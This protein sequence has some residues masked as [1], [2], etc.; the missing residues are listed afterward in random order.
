MSSDGP[1][2]SA[3]ALP[4]GEVNHSLAY[5]RKSHDLTPL[6]EA[7]RWDRRDAWVV[8]LLLAAV[9]AAYFPVLGL[10]F[11]NWDDPYILFRNRTLNPPT[12]ASVRAW[13]TRPHEG[14]Y[15]PVAYTVWGAVAFIHW[16]PAREA[17]TG[18]GLHPLPFHALNLV[19]FSIT[20]VVVYRLLRRLVGPHWPAA[21]GALLFALHPIQVESV[22]HA[23]GV[24]GLLCVLFSLLALGQY[25][26][27][28]E[29]SPGRRTLPGGA[30]WPELP[31]ARWR[32]YVLA[33]LLFVIAFLC[34]PLGMVVPVMAGVLDVFFVGRPVRRAAIALAPWLLLAV[35][36]AVWTKSLQPPPRFDVQIPWWFRPGVAAD[37]VAVYL[38]KLVF[39][40]H[41]GLTYGRTPASLMR[42]DAA[43][44]TWLVPVALA[45][46]LWQRRRSARPLVG[47]ALLF[48]AALLP[49][50][51][52]ARFN[53][54]SHS[55]V[56]DRYMHLPMFAVALAAAWA[57]ARPWLSSHPRRVRVAAWA[58][59]VV[60]LALAVRTWFQTHRWKD[61]DTLLGV[62][63]ARA[64]AS[65]VCPDGARDVCPALA[66]MR[67]A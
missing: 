25:L 16:S 24:Q 29:S 7:R 66:T 38:Y 65:P 34:K 12:A 40:A 55:T 35:A 56:A 8:V 43:F 30:I 28:A 14:L 53:Y 2:P 21:A 67:P 49:V 48:V 41:L 46:A 57:L 51:G 27:F 44:Y 1:D 23:S 10:P 3:Q 42:S 64:A 58:C 47:A 50:L 61:T 60:L 6:E 37:A 26:R 20:C 9:L 13:W 54:Q 52:L 11:V 22:A 59:G 17:A 19:V 33:T 15:T 45:V 39:P 18:T 62:T 32:H 36:C 63:S 5:S 4:S 31:A